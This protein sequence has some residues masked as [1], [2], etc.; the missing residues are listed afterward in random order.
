VERVEVALDGFGAAAVENVD[1]VDPRNQ[2]DQNWFWRSIQPVAITL[3]S[4]PACTSAL[5]SL[6]MSI[7]GANAITGNFWGKI[8]LAS[9]TTVI[10]AMSTT[11]HLAKRW[12]PDVANNQRYNTYNALAMWPIT[13]LFIFASVFTGNNKDH[14]TTATCLSVIAIA[15]SIV[16][17]GVNIRHN[18]KEQ[19]QVRNGEDERRGLEAR[20]GELEAR[21]GELEP[22]LADPNNDQNQFA[23]RPD[24]VNQG[25]VEIAQLEAEI[26]HLQSQ[27]NENEGKIGHLQ[28]QVDR[29]EGEIGRLEVKVGSLQ[30]QI[31]RDK[32]EINSLKDELNLAKGQHH[33]DQL[34]DINKTEERLSM[35][36]STTSELASTSRS[37]IRQR[38][39][40]NSP[41]ETSSASINTSLPYRSPKPFPVTNIEFLS[42]ELSIQI[43]INLAALYQDNQNEPKEAADCYKQALLDSKELGLINK[44]RFT[45]GALA[46]KSHTEGYFIEAIELYKDALNIDK[47]RS[48]AKKEAD[49]L[50]YSAVKNHVRRNMTKAIERYKMALD[51]NQTLGRKA[52]IASN[53]GHLGVAYHGYDLKTAIE[54]YVAASKIDEELEKDTPGWLFSPGIANNYSNL[55]NALCADGKP[56]EAIKYYTEALKI[57]NQLVNT[58]KGKASSYGNLG[59]AHH[60]LGLKH[61]QKNDFRKAENSYK[62][63][64]NNY[65][66]SEKSFKAIKDSFQISEVQ[67]LIAE[68]TLARENLPI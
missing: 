61:H 60:N 26:G 12:E 18:I 32:R 14:Q 55:G 53:L 41:E 4:N 25:E 68:V 63:A 15:I 34:M 20:V 47:K 8:G 42:K 39:F 10:C 29:G 56:N 31:N 62:E 19:D 24:Q 27:V 9:A 33:A 52:N 30:S 44:I 22:N 17:L 50:S 51:K 23:L 11:A 67:S 57:N 65:E 37:S 13:S 48:E 16:K 2:Q 35:D 38:K 7:A 46:L 43:Q 58:N 21:V 1:R 28:S 3:G 54:Y 5:D 36:E 45:M 49:K 59:I 66:L 6:E 40:H 64:I